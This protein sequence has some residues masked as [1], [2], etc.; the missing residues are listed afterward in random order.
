VRGHQAREHVR[1]LTRSTDAALQLQAVV[2]GHA[3]RAQVKRLK[4][5]RAQSERVLVLQRNWRGHWCRCCM[6]DNLQRK[7][8]PSLRPAR[9]SAQRNHISKK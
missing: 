1:Q 8:G 3:S 7:C 4:R 2:R 6:L 5:H 9:S